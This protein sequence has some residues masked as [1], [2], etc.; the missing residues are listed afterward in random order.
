MKRS[1]YLSFMLL[2]FITGN[3]FATTQIA[4]SKVSHKQYYFR[5]NAV[6]TITYMIN[7]KETQALEEVYFKDIWL[8]P[9]SESEFT[10]MESMSQAPQQNDK[11]YYL[12]EFWKDYADGKQESYLIPVRSIV[13]IKYV[14]KKRSSK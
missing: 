10:Y 14:V 9:A 11:F 12:V 5:A 8:S 1:I 6:Y 3:L 13:E 7:E 4:G 2:L